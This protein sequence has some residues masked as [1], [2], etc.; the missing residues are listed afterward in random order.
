MASDIGNTLPPR[1]FS[2]PIVELVEIGYAPDDHKG[3]PARIYN[4]KYNNAMQAI[5]LYLTGGAKTHGRLSGPLPITAGGT[6]S[7][8]A[9]GLVREMAMFSGNDGTVYKGQE[10][11]VD[12]TGVTI[13]GKPD[14]AKYVEWVDDYTHKLIGFTK[15]RSQATRGV[16]YAKVGYKDDLGNIIYMPFIDK[17]EGNVITVTGYTLTYANGKLA[18]GQK[19]KL[20]EGGFY[21]L[22]VE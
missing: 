15:V 20:P 4:M 1:A 13:K 8:T 14:K 9:Q 21:F 7:S 18:K 19:T 5:M 17:I 12:K 3:E 10:V 6:G 2:D 16:E 11:R 22:N